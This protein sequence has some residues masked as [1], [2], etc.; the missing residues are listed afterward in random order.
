MAKK[1]NNTL[2]IAGGA[3]L[4][5]FGY[6]QL[7]NVAS[8]FAQNFTTDNVRLSN[9]DP[10]L[11]QTKLDLSIDIINF[12]NLPVRVRASKFDLVLDGDVIGTVVDQVGGTIAANTTSQLS[13]VVR[14]STIALGSQIVDQIQQGG[15]LQVVI[16]RLLNIQLR[17]IGT[18]FGENGFNI[19]IN[20]IVRPI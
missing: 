17:V 9:V 6:M 2:L 7:G 4:A 12:N 3:A 10:G 13:G 18:I 11:T 20:Q 8:N 14:I 19:D 5:Y 15:S 16:S 1:S